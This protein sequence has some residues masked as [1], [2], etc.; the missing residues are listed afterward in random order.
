MGVLDR[1]PSQDGARVQSGGDPAAARVPH[2]AGEGQA[3]AEDRPGL[4][5]FD[6]LRTEEL[7]RALGEVAC[8]AQCDLP[9]QVE[10]GA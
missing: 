4:L 3:A 8:N 1:S 6:K 9:A 5:V 10:V 7:V 2:L